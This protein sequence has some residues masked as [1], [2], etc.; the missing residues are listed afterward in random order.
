MRAAGGASGVLARP[1]LKGPVEHRAGQ[2]RPDVPPG[3][4][5]HGRGQAGGGGR[6]GGGG[7]G[8]GRGRGGGWGRGGG[9]GWG[10][11]RG[12]GDAGWAGQHWCAAPAAP[13]ARA[14]TD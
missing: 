8:A 3:R 4:L 5:G 6:G 11:G 7:G 12:W 10:G 14:I 13:S 1:S 9:G 2:H